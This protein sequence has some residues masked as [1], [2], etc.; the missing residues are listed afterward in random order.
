MFGGMDPRIDEYLVRHGGVGSREGLVGVVG[1]HRLD[2]EIKTGS[3]VSVF[4]RTYARPWDADLPDVLMRAAL[5]SVG[6]DVALSH[7]TALSQRALPVPVG[8][9]I[10]VTAYNPR[11]PRS[12]PGRL[13][14]HRTKL[15]LDAVE[16]DGLPTVRLEL[17]LLNSWPLLP[18]DDRRAPLIEASRR[19]LLRPDRI[20]DLAERMWWLSGRAELG[21]LVG[22]LLAGC[23]SELEMWGYTEV[24][25]VP[26]LNHA[27]RQVKVRVGNKRYRLD[28]YY[29]EEKHN[30]ELD[31]RKYHSSP[32][33]RERDLDRDIAVARLGI[34]TIRFS[35][36][37]LRFDVDGCRADA[38]AVRAAR[39]RHAG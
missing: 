7:L 1:R 8:C 14:V 13:I 37:R 36:D 28:Q 38:L 23:E 10:H 33:Q 12:I 39:R 17:S 29:A 21:E 34:Q 3:L 24:F 16:V 18:A 27:T 25:D 35:H 15:P 20:A 9:P 5:A 11:H 4:P 22:L 2:N 32:E 6:G 26:G 19:K 31:G 30:I